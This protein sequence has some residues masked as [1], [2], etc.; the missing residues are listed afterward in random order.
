MKKVLPALPWLLTATVALGT[1]L[2]LSSG[3]T[4][5]ARDLAASGV[6]AR[7]VA[8]NEARAQ[9]YAQKLMNGSTT[10]IIR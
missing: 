6:P 4:P 9:R 7:D 5:Q 3:Y 10:G 8:A 1:P 2:L